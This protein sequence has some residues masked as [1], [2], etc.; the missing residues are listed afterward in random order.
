MV[1]IDAEGTVTA[2]PVSVSADTSVR[3]FIS[4]VMLD[5]EFLILIDAAS[6][7]VVAVNEVDQKVQWTVEGSDRAACSPVLIEDH[8]IVLYNNGEC[9]TVDVNNG[10]VLAVENCG[11]AIISSWTEK[12]KIVAYAGQDRITWDGEKIERESI[13][14]DIVNA[15]PGIIKTKDNRIRTRNDEGRF[16]VE[17]GRLPEEITGQPI[18]WNGHAVCPVGNTMHIIGP[19]GFTIKASKQMLAPTLLDDLL[20]VA[21]A[22]GT[23]RFLKQ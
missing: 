22:D 23:V 14:K 10:N 8:L 17:L 21:S 18:L 4:P 13:F 12:D 15:G 16:D 20:I 6:G 11:N 3:H 2:I 9:K 5:A 7:T 19:R 1:K